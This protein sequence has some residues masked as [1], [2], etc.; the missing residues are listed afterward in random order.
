MILNERFDKHTWFRYIQIKKN[1]YIS[2]HLPESE[3]TTKCFGVLLHSSINHLAL[4]RWGAAKGCWICWG[5]PLRPQNPHATGPRRIATAAWRQ[6]CSA[7]WIPQ[8]KPGSFA[9]ADFQS[10]IVDYCAQWFHLQNF[11]EVIFE[12]GRPGSRVQ[13]EAASTVSKRTQH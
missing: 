9:A 8:A 11:C 7:T 10:H 13:S 3:E 5:W 12:A 4:S 1:E 2:I 6:R